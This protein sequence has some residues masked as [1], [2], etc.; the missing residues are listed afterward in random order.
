MYRLREIKC[1]P[2]KIKYVAPGDQ[3]GFPR[4][5]KWSCPIKPNGLPQVEKIYKRYTQKLGLSKQ[6]RRLLQV[7]KL[8]VLGRSCHRWIS[9]VFTGS[10]RGLF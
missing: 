7:D 6:A 8:E 1:Y 3:R 10:E 5:S 2:K 4:K 9:R